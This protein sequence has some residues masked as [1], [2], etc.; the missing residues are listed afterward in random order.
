[1]ASKH[2]NLMQQHHLLLLQQYPQSRFFRRDVG[3][4]KTMRDTPI[5][6]GLPGQADS[7]GI[8]KIEKFLIHVE[9][10]YKI[11]KDIQSKEQKNWQSMIESLGG[12]YILVKDTP[13]EAMLILKKRI[14]ELHECLNTF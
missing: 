4:F 2:D 14:M 7:W 12:I 5:R 6:I 3:M 10:E 8:I 11:G 9:F 13:D 1:M